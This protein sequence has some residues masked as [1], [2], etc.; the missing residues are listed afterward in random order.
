MTAKIITKQPALTGG[1]N[2]KWYKYK[3][4]AKDNPSSASIVTDILISFR[5]KIYY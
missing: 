2:H 4:I 3:F 5:S 1:S